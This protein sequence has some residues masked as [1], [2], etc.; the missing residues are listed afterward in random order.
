M[1][2]IE[3]NPTQLKKLARKFDHVYLD[4]DFT[5]FKADS[6]IFTLNLLTETTL[7]SPRYQLKR[8]QKIRLRNESY[9]ARFLEDNV[10]NFQPIEFVENFFDPDL[11][12]FVRVTP[13]CVILSL[14]VEVVIKYYLEQVGVTNK[15]I[16]RSA[17][18]DVNKRDF[19]SKNDAIISDNINDFKGIWGQTI[20]YV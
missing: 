3:Y 16:G 2:L 17:I 13:N 5:L 7:I 9:R 10:S 11:L 4:F 19:A 20:L 14:G 15:I 18:K 6:E 12:E 1:P 8:M